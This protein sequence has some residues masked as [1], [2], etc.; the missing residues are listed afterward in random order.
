MHTTGFCLRL[1]VVG[2]GEWWGE[3]VGGWWGG[4]CVDGVVAA[5]WSERLSV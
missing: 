5:G 2:W 3:V 1:E 4:A